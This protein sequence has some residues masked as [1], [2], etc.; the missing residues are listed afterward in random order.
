MWNICNP[1]LTQRERRFARRR[2]PTFW[3][4][5]RRLSLNTPIWMPQA[6][7]RVSVL[8]YSG[9]YHKYQKQ[10]IFKIKAN[11]SKYVNTR[12]DSE[13]TVEITT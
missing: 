7:P 12:V 4:S 2:L 9:T 1:K 10:C 6:M 3:C 5:D 11:E 13:K 8:Q